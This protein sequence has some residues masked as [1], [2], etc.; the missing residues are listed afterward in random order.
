MREWLTYGI[1]QCCIDPTVSP[2]LVRGHAP[3]VQLL[4]PVSTLDSYQVSY[5]VFKTLNINQELTSWRSVS[6]GFFILSSSS[7]PP[8]DKNNLSLLS[9]PN[10]S[11]LSGELEELVAVLVLHWIVDRHSINREPIIPPG[12][13]SIAVVRPGVP[14]YSAIGS[15]HLSKNKLFKLIFDHFESAGYD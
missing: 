9:F 5:F 10:R 11:L 1:R 15:E 13:P 4:M 6:I 2:F 3:V 7:Y 12:L 8:W 14:A